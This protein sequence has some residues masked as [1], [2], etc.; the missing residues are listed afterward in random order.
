VASWAP[1]RL[2]VVVRGTD[3]AIYHLWWAASWS[4]WERRGGV[5]LGDPGATSSAPNSLDIFCLGGNAAGGPVWHQWLRGNWSGWTQEEPGTWALGVG[6]SSSSS[7][8]VDIFG[9]DSATNALTHDWW[10]GHRW[11][12]EI[13]EGTLGS[14]PTAIATGPSHITVF[15][16]GTD[17]LLYQRT[18]P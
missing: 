6:A 16:Q 8:R 2:D 7:A 17:G 15:V 13:V 3:Q 12:Y 10:D 14:T 9:A 11:H 1:D 18:I 4:G 5:C